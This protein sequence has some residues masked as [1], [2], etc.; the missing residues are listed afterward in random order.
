MYKINP[1]CPNC[2]EEH[3]WWQFQLTD[4][5][6]E[7]MD[8]YVEATKGKSSI[9]ILLSEPGIFVSREIKCSCCGHVFKVKAGLRK[10]DEVGYR[11]RDH[12]AAVGEIPV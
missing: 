5:E 7:K 6:Q 11:D 4:E 2:H 8:A 12:I 9:E 3:M 1:T 10:Y